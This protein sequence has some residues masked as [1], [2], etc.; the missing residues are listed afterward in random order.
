MQ[1]NMQMKNISDTSNSNCKQFYRYSE[2]KEIN[3]MNN[4]Y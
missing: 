2:T 1:N 3:Y 4:S